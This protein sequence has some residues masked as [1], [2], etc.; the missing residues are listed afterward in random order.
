MKFSISLLYGREHNRHRFV[1]HVE[2]NHVVGS[3]I[4]AAGYPDIRCIQK[5]HCLH[6][7]ADPRDARY[8]M[9][10]WGASLYPGWCMGEAYDPRTG[11][12][13]RVI[14]V[15]VW[16][17]ARQDYVHST[18]GCWQPYAD[19]KTRSPDMQKMALPQIKTTGIT[20]WGPRLGLAHEYSSS[21]RKISLRL[22][23][24]IHSKNCGWQ[25][26]IVKHTN[27]QMDKFV[28]SHRGLATGLSR[29]E[30]MKTTHWRHHPQS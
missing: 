26:S 21:T 30:T 22:D 19:R 18:K 3:G 4:A 9:I 12:S 17:S 25:N 16:A 28:K 14:A 6:S 7:D 11:E 27:G 2:W 13:S 10:N 20:K 1:P 23:Y 24:L 8:N 15:P 29:K 5:A